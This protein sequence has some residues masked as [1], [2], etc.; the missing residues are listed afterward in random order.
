VLHYTFM[1]L[2]VCITLKG[3]WRWKNRASV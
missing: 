2:F 3:L 1:F